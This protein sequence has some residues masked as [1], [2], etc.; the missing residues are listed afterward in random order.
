M[1]APRPVHADAPAAIEPRGRLDREAIVQEAM[2]Q[3]EAEG[4]GALSMR[5]LAAALGVSPMSLYSHVRDKADLFD[6]LAH[7]LLADTVVPAVDDDDWQGAARTLFTSLRA[8]L[9][10]KRGAL[11]LLGDGTHMA[12]VLIRFADT[13]MRVMQRAGFEGADAVRAYRLLAYFTLGQVRDETSWPRDT[14]G[15]PTRRQTVNAALAT[16]PDDDAPVFI[17]LMPHSIDM[18]WDDLFTYGLERLIDSLATD[19]HRLR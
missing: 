9:L 19:P 1:S 4:V 8:Q 2:R 18:D 17:G 11:D 13:G 10:S 6:A 14:P 3:V 15:R 5:R 16:L 12:P 7:A